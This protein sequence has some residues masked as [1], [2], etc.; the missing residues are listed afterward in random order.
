M[1]EQSQLR[2]PSN[3]S[4]LRHGGSLS[5]ATK[6][7]VRVAPQR[8]KALLRPTAPPT[9][10]TSPLPFR[11]VC[12][13][14]KS[15]DLFCPSQLSAKAGLRTN[16]PDSELGS[17]WYKHSSRHVTLV[18]SFRLLSRRSP[19]NLVALVSCRRGACI[20]HAPS[21]LNDTYNGCL[22]CHLPPTTYHLPPP[23]PL[24]SFLC[25]LVHPHAPPPLPPASLHLHIAPRIGLRPPP[26]CRLGCTCEASVPHVG[27]EQAALRP[28]LAPTGR[29][30]RERKKS[31]LDS[32]V[33]R[34][35]AALRKV[36][37]ELDSTAGASDRNIRPRRKGEGVGGWKKGVGH[38]GSSCFSGRSV[39]V[40]NGSN[41][42]VQIWPTEGEPG[43]VGRGQSELGIKTVASF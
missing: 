26:E 37:L 36:K 15:T 28:V 40:A 16:C 33:V 4:I 14:R 1:Q 39:R 3:A 6:T 9:Q 10:P 43:P 38:H 24:A 17:D 20:V 2:Q 23:P 34:R 32:T 41:F 27:L 25:S 31:L 12:V 5:A 22:Y 11:A 35:E 19:P 21:S 18:A 7:P 8:Y 29:G 30:R 13:T 42:V